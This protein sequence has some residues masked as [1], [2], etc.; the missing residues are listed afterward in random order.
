MIFKRPIFNVYNLCI[1][2]L[3]LVFFSGILSFCVE[4]S[5]TNALN[6]ANVKKERDP[7]TVYLATL[8]WAPY[9]S[10]ELDGNG[11]VYKLVKESYETMGMKVDIQYY[12]F[13]RILKLV[14]SGEIDGYFPEYY[15]EDYLKEYEFSSPYPGGDVGLFKRADDD[16]KVSISSG[17]KDFQSLSKYRLGVVRGY[18]N[19][20]DFDQATYLS[21][22]E[23]NDDVSNLKKLY[24]KRVQ[25]IFIDYNVASFLIHKHIHFPDAKQKLQ[26]I[27][28]PLENKVLY[29]CY[30]RK[31]KG[32]K[33]K[34]E[35]FNI[36][37]ALLQKK[38]RLKEILKESHF[39]DGRYSE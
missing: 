26:F 1:K 21:K 17:M 28:P 32:Y 2:L 19:T 38:G 24:Y 15:N 39:I 29:N 35:K 30:S 16:L 10:P 31:S 11:Y 12:P 9:I 5:T 6:S 33:D 36:G 22:E 34:L 27:E 13:A 3:L 23:T 8:E 14:E 7:N 18:V 20:K 4:K 37:F 25:M